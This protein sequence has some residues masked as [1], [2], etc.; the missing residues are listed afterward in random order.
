MVVFWYPHKSVNSLRILLLNSNRI[1]ES[2]MDEFSELPRL[3]KANDSQT[4]K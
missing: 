3:W 1:L 2:D 4:Y